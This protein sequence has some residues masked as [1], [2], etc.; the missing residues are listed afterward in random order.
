[1]EGKIFFSYSRFDATFALKLATDLTLAGLPVWIDQVD[2]SPGAKWDVTVEDAL[3]A[4]GAVPVILSPDAVASS[5][6][7]DEVSFALESGRKILPV[8]YKPCEIPFRLRRLQHL[9][10]TSNYSAGLLALTDAFEPVQSLG[11]G[12]ASESSTQAPDHSSID[13][14]ASDTATMQRDSVTGEGDMSLRFRTSRLGTSIWAG[15]AGGLVSLAANSLIYAHD[16]RRFSRSQSVNTYA[17]VGGLFAGGLWTIA[18]AVAGS[19]RT[20]VASAVITSLVVLGLWVGIFGTYQDVLW[21]AVS[22]GGPFAGIVG[23]LVSSRIQTR[24]MHP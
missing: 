2:I 3:R 17:L 16:P 18:G 6:V 5:S 7:M 14:L 9:D 15:L 4:C 19:N 10:F 21:T 1:M 22:F 23:A 11:A 8:V 13:N 24:K 20:S 12:N